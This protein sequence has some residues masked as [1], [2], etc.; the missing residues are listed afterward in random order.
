[1]N[2]L[3][4]SDIR[5]CSDCHTAKLLSE[6]YTHIR[7]GY[8]FTCKE[9]D[10]KRSLEYRRTKIGLISRIYGSQKNSSKDRGYPYPSYTRQE[11]RDWMFSQKKFHELYDD[12]VASGYDKMMSPSCDRIDDYVS[13][14]LSNI[15]LM[16]WQENKDKG[17]RDRKNGINNKASKAVICF[18]LDDG[19][20]G[21]FLS[22]AQASRTLSIN[23]SNIYQCC[24]GNRETAGGYLWEFNN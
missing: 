1:M 7:D 13:Y 20:C 3:N 11:L 9:C 6:F 5:L 18:R 15:Q 14:T 19:L 4:G 10:S 21:D 8:A 22:I 16:T 23:Q 17:H 24:I 12:W 2:T